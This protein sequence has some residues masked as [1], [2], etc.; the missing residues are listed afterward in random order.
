MSDQQPAFDWQAPSEA[1]GPGPGLEFAPHGPRLVA[2]ILDAVIL[3]LIITVIVIAG[4]VVLGL[5]V[6]GSGEDARVSSPAVIGFIVLLAVA[7]V[8][9]VAYF[10]WFWARRGQ[11]PGMRPFG[12]WVVRDRD[13][14][15]ISG[16][17][18][19]LRLVGTVVSSAVVYLGFIWIFIDARRRGWHDLIA[20]TVVVHRP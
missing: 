10:P 18:A 20:G 5:G 19:V 1:P 13:G 9:S 16:G 4:V 11:T 6:T 15:P 17:T 3:T 2:Y 8:V 7:I 14:G 12:L